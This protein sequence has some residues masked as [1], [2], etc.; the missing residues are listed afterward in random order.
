MSTLRQFSP[1]VVSAILAGSA[2]A[3][4]PPESDADRFVKRY[5]A[6]QLLWADQGVTLAPFAEFHRAPA[7]A[8]EQFTLVIVGEAPNLAALEIDWNSRLLRGMS[9]LIATDNDLSLPLDREDRVLV[10]AGPFRATD[11]SAAYLNRPDQ[12]VIRRFKTSPL[13]ESVALLAL[14]EP[15]VILGERLSA[16]ELAYLPRAVN[17]PWESRVAVAGGERGKGR[18]LVVADQSLFTNE[19]I[20]EAHNARFADNAVRWLIHDRPATHRRLVVLSD[21]RE[22]SSLI[23]ERFLS[24]QW[25][26][27][28]TTN[29]LLNELLVGLEEEDIPNQLLRDVQASASQPTPTVARSVLLVLFG[30]VFAASLVWRILGSRQPALPPPTQSDDN[31]IWTRGV[32]AEP[33]LL[34]SDRLLEARE[35]DWRAVGNYADTL[36]TLARE[37]FLHRLGPDWVQRPPRLAAPT[38]LDAWSQR[39]TVRFL[40]KLA[41]GQARPVV[42][43]QKFRFWRDRLTQLDT[44]MAKGKD[45]S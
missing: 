41:R 11:P 20:R 29:E 43:E 40:W 27:V 8:W 21:R 32:G 33:I 24:G 39:R 30:S 5:D 12:P 44:M 35:K 3:Q 28:P 34:R 31:E 14:K 26:R 23:D 9:L 37:T 10:A 2:V 18:F 45:G 22:L 38:L 25:G 15:G 16:W 1:L 13:F 36:A 7:D 4:D 17:V 42:T 6:F 19:M